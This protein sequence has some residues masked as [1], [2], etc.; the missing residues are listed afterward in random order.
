MFK[1]ASAIFKGREQGKGRGRQAAS[2]D[3]AQIYLLP[4]QVGWGRKKDEACDDLTVGSGP[5][6]TARVKIVEVW[7]EPPPSQPWETLS[8]QL[9]VLYGRLTIICKISDESI[10]TVNN[11]IW[12]CTDLCGGNHLTLWL[13][14]TILGPALA[15]TTYMFNLLMSSARIFRTTTWYNKRQEV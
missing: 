12:N 6:V 7:S 4:E 8:W 15:D 9:I 10:W 2:K 13:V 3:W 14:K 5:K 11:I 1:R